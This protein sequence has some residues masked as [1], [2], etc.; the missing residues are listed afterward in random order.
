MEDQKQIIVD[1]NRVTRREFRQF[2]NDL[3]AIPEDQVE[4]REEVMAGFYGK[5]VVSWPFE[6]P[7]SPE[8]YLSLG[9]LDARRVDEAVSGAISEISEK[10]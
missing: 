9:M 3:K 4:Q 8:G 6:V 7:V 1:M 5:V 10:K 2:R